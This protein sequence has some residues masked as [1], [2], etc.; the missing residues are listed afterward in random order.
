MINNLLINN[1]FLHVQGDLLSGSGQRFIYL[2]P[3]E[4]DVKA[5]STQTCL[6]CWSD[7][8]EGEENE[9]EA[10]QKLQNEFPQC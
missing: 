2:F 9:V 3:V 10:I 4:E 7:V 6:I 8:C 5:H 1:A